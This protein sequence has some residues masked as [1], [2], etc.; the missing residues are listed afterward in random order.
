MRN[1]K[2]LKTEI[3]D[4]SLYYFKG[5]I[6]AYIHNYINYCKCVSLVSYV[7]YTC[8]CVCVCVCVYICK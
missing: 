6:C 5:A 7:L 2:Y 3:L 8:V 4:L 1:I